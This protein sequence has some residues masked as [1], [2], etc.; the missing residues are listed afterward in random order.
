MLG[1]GASLIESGL[2]RMGAPVRSTPRAPATRPPRRGPRPAEPPAPPLPGHGGA[3]RR[4]PGDPGRRPDAWRRRRPGADRAVRRL[5]PRGAA[6]PAG[7]AG[8]GTG[9]DPGG[10]AGRPGGGGGERPRL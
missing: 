8:G 4:G 3:A 9:A 10:L 7:G 2:P 5:S 1:W 6:G